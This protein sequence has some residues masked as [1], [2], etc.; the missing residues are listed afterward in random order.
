MT[1]VLGVCEAW[2]DGVAVVRREDG[3]RVEIPTV[4]IVSGKPV[5]PRPSARM[6]VS[7]REAESHAAPLWTQVE[8]FPLGDWELRTD[9]APVD[10]LRKRANSCLAMGDPGVPV[11]EAIAAIRSFYDGRDRVA[12]AQVL[13]DSAEEAAFLT[14]GWRLVVPGEADLRLA[15]LATTRRALPRAD[16]VEAVV[17]E[18]G[19]RVRAVV[20]HARGDAALDGD[21]LGVHGMVTDPSYR[22]QGLA[23]RVLAALAEWGAEQGATTLWLHVETDNEAAVAL[24]ESLGLRVHHTCR[25]YA[26][27]D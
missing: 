16:D 1:D 14:A 5:P 22:R 13:V 9:P 25:Y 8:R 17:T 15:S 10:R 6:R 19:P 27:P 2:A 11:A 4:D 24:Y 7:S 12:L 23:R 18:D 3:T 21:W 26:A 20:G